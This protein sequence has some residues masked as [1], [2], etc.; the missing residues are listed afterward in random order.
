MSFANMLQTQEEM[1]KPSLNTNKIILVDRWLGS[2]FSYQA[3][4]Y[5]IDKDYQLFNLFNKQFIKPNMT[6]YLKIKP[7]LGLAR[8]QN[9]KG[10]KLDVIESNPLSY[11]NKVNQGYEVFLK[12]QNI[13]YKLIL[14]STN[15]NTILTHQKQIIKQIGV[16]LNGNHH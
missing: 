13:G 12:R 16:L 11:F 3:Y 1:M 14:K 15:D 6:V 4:P 8:K 9:Q 10:H 5:H 2:N 7:Q